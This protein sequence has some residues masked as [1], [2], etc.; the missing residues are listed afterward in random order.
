MYRKT[1]LD[2]GIRVVTES[3]PYFPTVSFGVWWKTGSRYENEENNGISHFIEHMLFKGTEKRTAHDIARDIDAV[4][5]VLNAFTGKEY[6]CLYARVL[7]QDM[8]IAL[9]VLADMCRHSTFDQEDIEREKQVVIQEIKMIEDNPEEWVFDM[10]NAD[11]YK[12]DP[13]GLPVLGIEETVER[14]TH[15]GLL[16]HYRTHHS[17]QNTIITAVGRIDHEALVKEVERLFAWPHGPGVPSSSPAK[18]KSFPAVHVYEKDLEHIYLCIGTDGVSQTDARRYAL[19]AMNAVVGGSMSS[20]LFQEI[21]E[22]RGLV[23][24]VF[25]YVNCFHDVGGFGISTSSSPGSVEEVIGL[26]K[27]EAAKL[28]KEGISPAELAFSR[29][30]I[31][32]NFFISLEGSEARMGRLAKNEIYFDRYIP[33]RETLKKIDHVQ[34]PQVDEMS[35]LAFGQP[36]SMALTVLGK[37]DRKK[38][39]RIWKR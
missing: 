28:K 5:G 30:H 10:F 14:F 7:K 1:V 11:Y 36:E 12:G 23:Y 16:D 19:Y 33:V 26:I 3:L 9:D 20:H 39:E 6:T 35:R 18:P 31:K 4:G 27:E 32:G 17:P 25:S 15:D 13:L 2:N 34:K 8:Q 24:N 21:R 37:V 38:I 29:E 22:K